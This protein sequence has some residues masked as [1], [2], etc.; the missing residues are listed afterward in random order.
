MLLDTSKIIFTGVVRDNEDTSILGRIRVF[1]EKNEDILQVLEGCGAKL[2]DNKTDIIDTE[3]FGPN[4]PFVFMPL[5]PYFISV[6]PQNGELVWVMYSDQKKNSGRKEQFYIPILKSDAF[7]FKFE[8]NNQTRTNTAQGFQ[9]TP[10][11]KYKSD[12]KNSQGKK[13]ETNP[14]K[15]IFA[16]PGDNAFYGQGSSDII[17]KK[18]E[19]ILRAGKISDVTSNKVQEPNEKRGFYQ[20]SFYN[21]GIEK[22]KPTTIT[23]SDIDKSFLKYLIEYE[24]YN[25]ENEFDLFRGFVRIYKLPESVNEGFPNDEFS[26]GTS[27]GLDVSQSV[28][29]CEFGPL[30]MSGVTNLINKII[31]GFNNCSDTIP[32]VISGDNITTARF[33]LPQGKTQFPFYYRPSSTLTNAMMNPGNLNVSFNQMRFKNA[34]TLT[35]QIKFS[36]SG[37]INGEGLISRKNIFGIS[38]IEKTSEVEG[39]ET[40]NLQRNSFSVAGSDKIMLLSYGTQPPGKQPILLPKETVYGLEQDFLFNTVIPNTEP[41]VR[42]ESLKKILNLMVK[43]MTTHSHPFHSLPPTPISYSQVSVAIIDQEFQKY[44]STVLNQNIRIN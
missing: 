21:K 40:Y 11:P 35:S 29:P 31:D 30:P 28:F 18:E 39:K 20:I 38:F 12:S 24:I 23:T 2:N 43:F 10:P 19:L 33:T 16:Q 44:D 32:L 36:S 9:L 42:G 22:D 6:I 15:G 37:D 8:N 1:P 41:V 34:V 17:L 13:E 25:L 4:D 26:I 14:I 3:K 7:N 27:V 5:F